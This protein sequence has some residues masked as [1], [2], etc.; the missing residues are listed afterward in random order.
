MPP[1][2]RQ[3][4][5]P[6]PKQS[7]NAFQALLD[8]PED[9]SD[10]TFD[11][12]DRIL[13]GTDDNTIVITNPH[14]SGPPAS[15]Q[16]QHNEWVEDNIVLLSKQLNDSEVM[17]YKNQQHLYDIQKRVMGLSNNQ[18]QDFEEVNSKIDNLLQEMEFDLISFD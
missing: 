15:Q 18:Q 17:H 11:G 10:S 5:A 13:D 12:R 2:P 6:W 1:K 9:G 3:L 14:D 16:L 7:G 8:H 4:R